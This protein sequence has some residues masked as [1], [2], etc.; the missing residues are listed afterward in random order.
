MLPGSLTR[1]QEPIL[2]LIRAQRSAFEELAQVLASGLE[3]TLEQAFEE[4]ALGGAREVPRPA[5]LT[6][7]LPQEPPIGLP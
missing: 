2:G 7:G 5:G 1:E 4:Q 3:P 6:S